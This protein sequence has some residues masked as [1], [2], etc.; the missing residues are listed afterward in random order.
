MVTKDDE[1]EVINA[2]W[3]VYRSGVQRFIDGD[4][5]AAKSEADYRERAEKAGVLAVA[6]FVGRACRASP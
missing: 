4:T 1:T 5:S 2:L 3:L 6:N